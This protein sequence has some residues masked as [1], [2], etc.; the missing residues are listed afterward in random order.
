MCI[1]SINQMWWKWITKFN[2]MHLFVYFDKWKALLISN[3]LPALELLFHHTYFL[4]VSSIP[5]DICE[6]QSNHNQYIQYINNQKIPSIVST[7]Q[8]YDYN[9]V[10]N[11]FSYAFSNVPLLDS[12]EQQ[13]VDHQETYAP[14]N[15]VDV[16]Q[17]CELI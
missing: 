11:L 9:Y 7:N 13:V 5:F 17:P 4:Y 10:S 2:R 16:T 1:P 14:A 12:Y 6:N 3:I 8:V 15:L